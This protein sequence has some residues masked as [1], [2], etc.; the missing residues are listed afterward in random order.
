M[1]RRLRVLGLGLLL[2][3]IAAPLG[4]AVALI[5]FPGVLPVGLRTPIRSV[6]RG[7]APRGR[8]TL[9]LAG[10]GVVVLLV[11]GLRVLY[12]RF[13]DDT[14]ARPGRVRVDDRLS[15]RQVSVTGAE[16]NRELAAAAASMDLFDERPGED[17]ETLEELEALAVRVLGRSEGWSP[18]TA[19]RRLATGAWTDDPRAAMV[20]AEITPPLRVRVLDRLR[21]QHRY[22]R[23]VE[24]ALSALESRTERARQGDRNE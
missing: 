2:A 15:A 1:D 3:A 5:W 17:A 23:A 16:H 24:A 8:P 7:L 21:R 4:V 13:G 10:I 18:E 14:T 11:E 6:V 12:R 22:E 19:R 9:V 20:F